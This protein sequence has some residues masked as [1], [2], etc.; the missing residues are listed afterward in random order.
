[1]YEYV[2]NWMEEIKY[3]LYFRLEDLYRV[4]LEDHLVL[5]QLYP[6]VIFYFSDYLRTFSDI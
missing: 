2:I 1:M 3:S 4:T 6:I 5:F